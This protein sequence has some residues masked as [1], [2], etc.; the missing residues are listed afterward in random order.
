MAP[1][2]F[3]PDS[4][5][6]IWTPGGVQYIPVPGP[7]GPPGPPNV[8]S[9]GTVTEGLTPDVTILGNSPNQVLNFVLKTGPK[10][11]PGNPG[12][13]SSLSIGTVDTLL[14]SDPATATITG[15]PPNQILN[16]GIPRGLQVEVTTLYPG[17]SS[18]A[19]AVMPS[20]TRIEVASPFAATRM[21]S[22]QVQIK[23]GNDWF[24]PGWYSDYFSGA[25]RAMGI[26]ATVKN[27]SDDSVA[28]IVVQSGLSGVYM[29]A[30]LSGA[31][32]DS[33]TP[34]SS[35]PFRVKVWG[36]PKT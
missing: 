19:P 27:N 28:T 11:D 31:G 3:T 30:N 33:L 32:S 15:T 17:G 4:G 1:D 36:T 20:D 5:A 21:L 35:A 2:D 12:Q 18:A 16:L 26:K 13:N 14:S 9:I 10:G 7:D 8:L 34:L 22:V 24:E 6:T 25:A 29:Q 23:I